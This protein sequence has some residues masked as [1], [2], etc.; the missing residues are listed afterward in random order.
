M[1]TKLHHANIFI[2]QHNCIVLHSANYVTIIIGHTCQIFNMHIYWKCMQIYMPHIKSLALNMKQEA[3]YTYL[4]YIT[5]QIWLQN[6]KYS[7]HDQH[8]TWTFRPNMFCT[9]VLK[10]S[11]AINTSHIIAKYV[12]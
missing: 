3:L 8:P 5:K 10:Q 1:L 2:T 4:T 11:N 6:S 7:S 9:H 12:L